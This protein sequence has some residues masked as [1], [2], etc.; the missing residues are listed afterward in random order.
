AG[1]KVKVSEA[2]FR[3]SRE[4]KA[5]AGLECPTD[6]LWDRRWRL[7]GPDDA[8]LRIRA[9]GAEGLRTCKDWRVIGLSRAALIVSPAIWRGEALVA[10]PLAGKANGW[11]A[12]IV[13]PFPQGVL[14]H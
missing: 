13:T 10:A 14:S 7:T 11:T 8:R 9:L 12:E 5:V 1:C 4:P 3:V 6:A 2:E